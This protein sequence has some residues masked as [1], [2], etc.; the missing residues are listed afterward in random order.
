MEIITFGL[1]A[2][3]RWLH[4]DG[5]LHSADGL[6][7]MIVD[8]TKRRVYNRRALRRFPQ[9]VKEIATD[10]HYILSDEKISGRV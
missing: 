10:D 5:T 8:E 1:F 6:I 7:E 4:R 2:A 3:R 9:Y